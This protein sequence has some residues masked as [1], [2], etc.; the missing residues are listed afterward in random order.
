MITNFNLIT[1][2]ERRAH[3]HPR[4]MQSIFMN[5]IC[6]IALCSCL[7]VFLYQILK[8]FFTCGQHILSCTNTKKMNVFVLISSNLKKMFSIFC[9]QH[10][11]RSGYIAASMH[12][13]LLTKT[14]HSFL[15][16]QYKILTHARKN[17]EQR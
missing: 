5:Y 17:S 16:K 1:I 6:F 10:R 7:F 11:I 12:Q 4:S 14:C 2:K 9:W 15:T 3:R 13:H 8:L